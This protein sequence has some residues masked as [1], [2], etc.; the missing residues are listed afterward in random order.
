M[1]WLDG[2]P[3]SRHRHSGTSPPLTLRVE[4][5]PRA[6]GG[7]VQVVVGEAAPPAE[8]A[9]G[10]VGSHGAGR[11]SGA[12]GLGHGARVERPDGAQYGLQ[13]QVHQVDDDQRALSLPVRVPLV[14]QLQVGLAE[15]V[16]EGGTV[17]A[18][19]HDAPLE[20]RTGA[21][22]RGAVLLRWKQSH[23]AVTGEE[24]HGK[25]SHDEK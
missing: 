2:R 15:A 23:R 4:Q 3:S 11:P 7:P 9:H 19:V 12:L 25:E 16:G 14:R 13:Q 22:R 24:L 8:G 20:H 5:Q 17:H 21:A 1:R 6:D 18:A 10:D